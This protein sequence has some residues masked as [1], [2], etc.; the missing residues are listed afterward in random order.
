M[1]QAIKN[2]FSALFPQKLKAF[3]ARKYMEQEY[4]AWQFGQFAY[5]QEGEDVALAKLM[6]GIENGHY[7]DIGC[8]HPARFSNTYMFYRQGWRGLNIDAKPNIVELFAQ[9]RPEDKTL[10]MGLGQESGEL[11]FYEFAETA[12]NTFSESL[13]QERI[14]G[15]WPL[16]TTRKIAVSSLADALDAHWPQG[17]SIELMSMD[18]E[19]LDEAVLRSNNWQKYRPRFLVLEFLETRDIAQIL[20]T[21]L[22]AFLKNQGYT[23]VAQTGRS[24]IFA[25]L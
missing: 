14:A 20:Q 18:I 21:E 5:S 1:K 23:W 15:G 7:I 13:A 17:Q 16:K 6:H 8:H 3:F 4:G 9:Y 19:G 25:L 2:L 24:S 22:Y 12:L 11:L 10:C